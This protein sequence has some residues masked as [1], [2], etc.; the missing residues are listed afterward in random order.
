MDEEVNVFCNIC[1]GPPTYRN[2]IKRS[3]LQYLDGEDQ[4]GEH[5]AYEDYCTCGAGQERVGMHC[6][7][8]CKHSGQVFK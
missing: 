8:D 3:S 2:L 1:G 6:I 4:L 7:R 5:D